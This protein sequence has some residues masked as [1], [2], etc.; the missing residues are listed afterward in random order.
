M[1]MFLP[2]LCECEQDRI[3]TAIITLSVVIFLVFGLPM[4]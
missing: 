1:R 2:L 3:S 4:K